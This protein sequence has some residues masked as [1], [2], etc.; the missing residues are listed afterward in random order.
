MMYLRLFS[1]AIILF[2]IAFL[3]YWFYLV[4][5]LASIIVFPFFVEAIVFGF[6]I[7]ILYGGGVGGLLL[8]PFAF[9]AMVLIFVSMPVQKRLRM[10]V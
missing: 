4:L 8:S 1:S 2:S 6:L 5:I 9:G 7:D 10:H 3:P